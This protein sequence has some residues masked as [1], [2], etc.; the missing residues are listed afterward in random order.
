MFTLPKASTAATVNVPGVPAVMGLGKPNTA[1]PCTVPAI[2]VMPVR[3]PVM[4]AVR[5]SV[6]VMLDVPGKLCVR[7]VAE[8]VCCPA[9]SPV[10]W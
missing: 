1:K 4:V 7:S 10:Y 9:S 8:N 6:T 5:L 3:L 2:T